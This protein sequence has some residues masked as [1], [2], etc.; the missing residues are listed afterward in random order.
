MLLMK[1]GSRYE[2]DFQNGEMTGKGRR[3]WEDGT[4]YSGEFVGGEK[5]GFGEIMYGKRNI[6]EH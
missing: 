1:D 2:G 4:E 3:T 5:E 6:K